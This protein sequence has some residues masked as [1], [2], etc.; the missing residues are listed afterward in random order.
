MVLCVFVVICLWEL[1]GIVGVVIIVGGVVRCWWFD[2]V[3]VVVEV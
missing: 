1:E 2:V 3:G